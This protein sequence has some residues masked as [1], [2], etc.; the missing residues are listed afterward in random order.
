MTTAPRTELTRAAAI[1]A[2][3]GFLLATATFASGEALVSA[4]F[5]THADPGSLQLGAILQVIDGLAVVL[6]AVALGGLLRRISPASAAG[7]LGVRLIELVVIAVYAAAAW[8]V[9]SGELTPLQAAEIRQPLLL[10]IYLLNGVA[11]L[12]LTIGLLRTSVPRWLG[13]LGVLGYGT[14]LVGS[15]LGLTGLL[16]PNSGPGM[17]TLAPGALFELA[18]PIYLLFLGA[19]GRPV[20]ATRPLVA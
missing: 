5:E 11:G 1:T 10:W 16:D 2:G 14:I 9:A 17:A 3:L 12:L 6:V 7:Y 8:R 15:V 18:F 20:M 4:A 19:V 13:W